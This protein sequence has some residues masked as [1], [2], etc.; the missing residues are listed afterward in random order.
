MS[1]LN[2]IESDH[3]ARLEPHELV[4]LLRFLLYAE[5]K[6]RPVAV[7]VPLQ[8]YVPDDG[9]DG[10]WH[11]NA[12]PTEY[13]PGKLTIYQVKAQELSEA[14]CA[15]AMLT[16][17][18]QIK[19]SVQEILD[20]EG[21][22]IFF[23]GRPY[24]QLAHGIESRI[25]AA[26]NALT[27]A[28]QK[29]KRDDQIGFLDSNKIAAWTNQHA[30]AVAYVC[31]CCQLTSLGMF[32]TWTDWRRDAIFKL[33]FHS[34]PHLNQCIESLRKHLSQP[35][36]IARITGLSGLG[37]TRLA[38]EVLRPPQ[39]AKE[40]Q[41]SILSNTTIYLDMENEP[42]GVF[43]LV[44]EIEAAG[45]SGTVVVDNC[46]RSWHLKLGDVLHRDGC[47]LSL[48]TLDYVPESAQV[49]VLHVPLEPHMMEDVIPEILKEL[50]QANRLN[51]NQLNHVASFAFGFPQIATLMAETGDTLDWARLDQR[52]LAT[53]I[54]WGR[55]A[56]DD[57]GMKI[58]CALALF[59][60]VGFES[61][62][63]AQKNFVRET[64]CKSLQLSVRDFDFAIRPFRERR[65]IQKAGDFVMVAPPPLAVALA[66]EWW[67]IAN[68]DE[69][70][71]LIPQIEE[72]GMT[73]SFCRRVQQLHFSQNAA[74]L[75]AQLCGDSGP[76]SDAEVL[77]SELGSQF[78]RAIVELN[79]SAAL[80]CIWRVFSN[81]SPEELRQVHAGRRN[82]IW[83]LEKL[84]W[85]KEHFLKGAELLLDF[86]AA[87]NET[88]MNN[89]TGQF[90]QLYQLYLAGTQMPALERISVV[91]RGLDSGIHE[92]RLICIE[93]LGVALQTFHF[94][95]TGGVEVRGSGLPQEDWSPTKNLEVFGYWIRSFRLL[96]MVILDG[97]AE[98]ALA[99]RV[100]GSHL[101]GILIP[102]LLAKLEPDFKEIVAFERNYWPEALNSIQDIFE[103][104]S[105]NQ[106]PESLKRL[107][108]W[109]T[110]LSPQDLKLRLELLVTKASNQHS[111]GTDGNYIDVAAEK[112]QRLAEELFQ[113]KTDFSAYL[114]DLQQGEQRQAWFFGFRLGQI[115]PQ[116]KEFIAKCL[117]SFRRIPPESRNPRLL[118]GFLHGQS[119]RGLVEETLQAIAED[120]QIVE[121][122]A[123]LTSMSDPRYQSLRRVI[124]LCLQGRIKPEQ[125]R[126][127]A[128]GSVLG[129]LSAAEV[130]EAF[131]E[132]A[133][134]VE[135][136]RGHVFEVV[137][138]Y[139]LNS[140]TRWEGCRD[141]IRQLVLLPN[142]ASTMNS[143]MD[144]HHW[145]TAMTKL[146]TQRQDEEL[147][148]EGTRQILE[149]QKRRE[150]R[151]GQDIYQRPVLGLI[152]T[153]YSNSC[154]PLVGSAILSPAYYAFRML[155][156]GHGFD[157]RETSVFWNVPIE[158]LSSWVR[159][160]PGGL[161]RLLG[162]M[163][164]F[165][166]DK[167]GEYHW[168]PS[169]LTLFD[170]GL[171]DACIGAITSSLFSYGWNGSKIPY[172]E[173]RLGLV[174]TLTA[175]PL[176]PVRKMAQELIKLLEDDMRRERKR[177]EEF[178]AGI[179]RND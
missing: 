35:G 156:G 101:R 102:P 89:A 68:A 140:E 24:V 123:S 114:D 98:S 142:F 152:L 127:F 104:D 42:A 172:I 53:K 99:K 91:E 162:T 73:E 49:G 50:P 143:S 155:L 154:W 118:A 41:Q 65:I 119:E 27:G 17:N 177:N 36:N 76:L 163:V 7:H 55:D 153:R 61:Q 45:M 2:R 122:V 134:K 133:E 4:M 46:E 28:G 44:S 135:S 23:C 109:I 81:R 139:V 40:T 77:N 9:E 6:H 97:S 60:H 149:A 174:R 158:I 79:P 54:L 96:K 110:W 70:K 67:E 92:K 30:A 31:K 106:T 21:C 105:P 34:N 59:T 71:A 32:R 138:M 117:D 82:L 167:A 125:I 120:E 169:V 147:A 14:D 100:L 63:I 166:V 18:G 108:E 171:D 95:R 51:E 5:A 13:I 130:V 25:E 58:I 129:K 86:A 19:R 11:G 20:E 43:A 8:I 87:E 164:L 90:K 170:K 111:K 103:Y 84:C 48:L 131:R 144:G 80:E 176:A 37:K 137:S 113:N 94:S 1:Y 151:Y 62:R 26:N 83:A 121:M 15:K 74:A 39:D 78:F 66:A 115:T 16:S 145:Q 85:E 47:R 112:A 38:F 175:H 124:D 22:Y 12:T 141:F 146:L 72:N 173:R 69:L 33:S 150:L 128:Y 116:G 52:K 165:T 126:Q 56:P 29:P 159:E 88:W 148:I 168:H 157:D 179:L 160:N 75:A 132:L 136:A 178:S 64:L 93:A 161:Q 57:R 10:R 107:E 3:V